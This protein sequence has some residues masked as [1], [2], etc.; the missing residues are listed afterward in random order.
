MKPVPRQNQ[1]RFAKS[2]RGYSGKIPMDTYYETAPGSGRTAIA[3]GPHAHKSSIGKVTLMI[4][5]LI[6][7]HDEQ[8]KNKFSRHIMALYLYAAGAQRQMISV[9]V[10]LGIS[11]SYQNLTSKPRFTILCRSWCIDPEDPIPSTPPSTPSLHAHVYTPPNPELLTAKIET[12]RVIHLRTLRQLTGAMRDMARGVAAT[13][14]Y[15]ASYDN[16]NK[17]FRAAEQVVGKTDSQENGT[18]STIW[19]LWKAT[20]E[21]MSINDLNSAFGMAALLSIDDILLSAPELQLMHKCL[22]HC[23]LR[24]IVEH[25][26]PEQ[27]DLHKTPLH[28]LPAWN[29]DESTIIGN[30]EVV[31]A[32][33]AELGFFAGDQLSIVRL[34]SLL[35]IRAGNEG[36]TRNPGSLSFHSTHLHCAP[37][38]L[39]SLLP[40]CTC[41]DLVF[42]S[43]YSC[44]GTSTLDKCEETIN[45]FMK[46]EKLAGTIHEKYANSER[47]SDLRWKR[48]MAE[49][50]SILRELANTVKAGDSGR[51]VL[52]LKLL[53]C[54]YRGNGRTKYAHKMLH[55]IHNL[56]KV[57][58]ASIRKIVLNNWLLNPTGN[59]FSWVEV[60]LMQEHM[61]YWIK[62]HRSSASWEWLEM[63]SSYISVLCRLSTM[64]TKVLSSDQGNKHHPAD[65]KNDILLLMASLREHNVY[66]IKNCVFAK[67]DGSAT[68]DVILVGAQQL[69]DSSLNPLTEYST[70]FKR[71]QSRRRLQPLMGSWSESTSASEHVAPAADIPL[72]TSELAVHSPSDSDHNGNS[73]GSED[74]NDCWNV[75]DQAVQ[76]LSDFERTLDGDDEPALTR[77]TA[78][79]VALDMDG[80]ED[81][82]LFAISDPDD[83]FLDD[84][85]IDNSDND[86]VDE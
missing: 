25:V 12:L 80:D 23:I 65:L 36:G 6:A 59:P 5:S 86:Y 45:T 22:C 60:D 28:P 35:N 21:E 4:L 46:L 72:L 38:L 75:D 55:L 77:N 29:I 16:I 27:I 63:V 7:L 3:A 62:A 76:Q 34:R 53:A 43:L 10:H 9:M 78:A 19:P 30:T 11:E 82:F 83:S 49:D 64:I 42:V 33:H 51:I 31:E 68:P 48:K 71:L 41:R 18:C 84:G 44:T 8:H 40:F 52:I 58:P 79:D 14:L 69:I 39:S 81:R 73:S 66:E 26:T 20:L 17:V 56:T 13:G 1:R 70:M 32:I 2:G 85:D 47:I 37:I 54:S 67:D 50:S 61:N 57:W 74:D 15:A 24:I